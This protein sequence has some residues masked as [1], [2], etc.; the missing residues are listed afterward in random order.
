MIDQRMGNLCAFP[1]L[2]EHSK[3]E[4]A[5]RYRGIEVGD[6]IELAERSKSDAL[7][8]YSQ[9]RTQSWAQCYRQPLLGRTG[10]FAVRSDAEKAAE[11]FV[12]DV[13]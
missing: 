2:L 10:S 1:L 11:Q 4:S 13:A 7:T 5:M 3:I 9:I 8:Q 12:S 6:A